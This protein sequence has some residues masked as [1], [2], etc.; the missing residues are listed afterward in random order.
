M[1]PLHVLLTWT[2][3][4]WANTV[5]VHNMF[6]I[7]RNWTRSYLR[8]LKFRP[9]DWSCWQPK[10]WQ[11]RVLF[12]SSLLLLILY[13]KPLHM[14]MKAMRYLLF[15]L[16]MFDKVKRKLN[17]FR[18][19][20][21]HSNGNCHGEFFS[22]ATFLVIFQ[23]QIVKCRWLSGLWVNEILIYDGWLLTAFFW[24]NLFE[25]FT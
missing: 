22:I 6:L 18:N 21:S 4:P 25:M 12:P 15:F 1:H 8:N 17:G 20:E 5:C 14:Q 23:T 3:L 19:L 24:W 16:C 11:V 13:G 10:A 7:W 2:R 9:K